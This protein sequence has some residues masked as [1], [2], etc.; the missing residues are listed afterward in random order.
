MKVTTQLFVFT[1]FCLNAINVFS[2]TV[3][4]PGD[5]AIILGQSD[6]P[7]KFAFYTKVDLDAGTEIYFTDC[8]ADGSGFRAPVCME[9]AVKYTAPAGGISKGTILIYESGA[10]SLNFSNYTDSRIF[11]GFL[12]SVNGDQIIAF[13]D[14]N[15]GDGTPPGQDPTFLFALNLASTDFLGNK[16]SENQTGLPS[17][18]ST[19]GTITALGV[20]RGLIEEWDNAVYDGDYDFG[21]YDAAYESMTD[22][23]NWLQLDATMGTFEN[24][25]NDIPG[26]I[27]LP[28]ELF[29][30]QGKAYDQYIELTWQT[31]MELNNDYMAI[32][33]SIDGRTFEEIG[34]Q[35]GMGNTFEMQ[36]YRFSDKNPLKGTNYYRLRQVDYD[37]TTT[38]H[39]VI[40][41]LFGGEGEKPR[42][43]PTTANNWV[44]LSLKEPLSTSTEL[45]IQNANGQIVARQLLQAGEQQWDLSIQRLDAGQYFVQLKL[46]ERVITERFFKL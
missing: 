14:A 38:Y 30:F 7:N 4:S 21:S 8:G 34:R 44:S 33:R 25:V 42:L 29:S 13:Q 15:T 26:S 11:G 27:I 31:A 2:Q 36:E 19:S 20:G 6:N 32:E 41:V 40:A 39:K 5:I 9:G 16:S 18:L 35:T 22:I 23:N 3:L 43:Y 28:I 37:G 10:G 24:A 1:F 17:G 46:E 45:L 12:L